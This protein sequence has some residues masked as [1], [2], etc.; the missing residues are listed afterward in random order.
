MPAKNWG[1]MKKQRGKGRVV[2][3][4]CGR[5]VVKGQGKRSEGIRTVMETRKTSEV[6]I[7]DT[8]CEQGYWGIGQG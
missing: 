5:E 4:N 7:C 1:T 2:M 3:K 6:E 8:V